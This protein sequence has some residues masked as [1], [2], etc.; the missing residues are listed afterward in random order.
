MS[1]Y[2]HH[3]TPA[4]WSRIPNPAAP[5]PGAAT[6]VAPAQPV[7]Q[8]A[9]AGVLMIGDQGALGPTQGGPPP[10]VM[11]PPYSSATRPESH[12]T[13]AEGLWVPPVRKQIIDSAPRHPSPGFQQP[14]GPVTVVAPTG[15]QFK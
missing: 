3:A 8:T 12:Q 4:S 1:K 13:N 7:P 14:S 6:A 15:Q 2:L 5:Q 9:R 11:E 10:K